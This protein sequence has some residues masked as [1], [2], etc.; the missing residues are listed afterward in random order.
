M[1]K[2]LLVLIVIVLSSCSIFDSDDNDSDKNTV[3]LSLNN[4]TYEMK[5]N[6][7]IHLSSEYDGLMYKNIWRSKDENKQAW[8]IF[9]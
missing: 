8:S 4:G 9:I 5:A 3:T 7:N 1:K 6:D 2:F